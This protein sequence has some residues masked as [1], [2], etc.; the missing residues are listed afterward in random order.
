METKISQ[1]TIT[2]F[3]GIDDLVLPDLGRVNVFAGV[4]NSGKTSVLEAIGLLSNPLD[5]ANFLKWSLMRAAQN[6]NLS[7]KMADYLEFLFSSKRPIQFSAVVDGQ[8]CR[9]LYDAVSYRKGTASG[10]QFKAIEISASLTAGQVEQTEKL[11]FRNDGRSSYKNTKGLFS[12]AHIAVGSIFYQNCVQYISESMLNQKKGLLLD[13]IRSFDPGVTDIMLQNDDILLESKNSGVQPLFNYGSGLQKAVLLASTMLMAEENVILIDEID[14][15][16]NISA[17]QEVFPWFIRKCQ[18]LDIQAFV[19]THSLEAIDAMLEAA[20]QN[21]QDDI[22]VITLRKSPK[23]H[24]VLAQVRS[25]RDAL[26]DRERFEMEL[27]I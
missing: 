16:I 1:L 27:R 7:K 4:N 22:R 24:R 26:S 8:E 9:V 20:E 19:T 6:K 3:R 12:T 17:F 11:Y 13:V 2:H 10:A 25:G 21:G 23:S 5:R 18:E 14:S 15:T